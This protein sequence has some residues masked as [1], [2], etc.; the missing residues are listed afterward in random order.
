MSLSVRYGDDGVRYAF[1]INNSAADKRL[2]LSEL[3][4]GTELLT[5]AVINDLIELDPYGVGV[6]ALQQESPAAKDAY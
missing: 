3:N 1:L 4:G 6:I 5:G 2:C